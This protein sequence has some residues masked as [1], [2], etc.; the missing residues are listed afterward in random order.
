MRRDERSSP[1]VPGLP[2]SAV[3]KT[4]FKVV[5]RGRHPSKVLGQIDE[6]AKAMTPTL[7]TCAEQKR[8]HY[9]DGIPHHFRRS[10]RNE[11][12]TDM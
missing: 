8:G 3:L 12:R 9:G 1:T 2:E 10:I 5:E 6:H 4:V 7:G 11:G